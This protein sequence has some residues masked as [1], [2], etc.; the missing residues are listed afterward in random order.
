MAIMKVE[1]R[2]LSLLLD[3][4]AGVINLNKDLPVNIFVGGGFLFFVF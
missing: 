1:S 4:L 3:R 2:D